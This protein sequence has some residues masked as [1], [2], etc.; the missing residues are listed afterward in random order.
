VRN[1]W[2]AFHFGV[3]GHDSTTYRP[4]ESLIYNGW[5]YSAR[6]RL[7]GASYPLETT[8]AR[9][10]QLGDRLSEGTVKQRKHAL[11]LMFSRISVSL[12][13]EITEVEP[14]P[15]AQPL[16]VDLVALSGDNKC[17]QGTS[18]ARHVATLAGL[19]GNREGPTALENAQGA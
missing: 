11:S 7:G 8:L 19:E 14:Q 18:N 2:L 4:G 16:F 1:S 10:N 6:T 3:A 5:D 9:I 12:T 15:W 17:P 13:G